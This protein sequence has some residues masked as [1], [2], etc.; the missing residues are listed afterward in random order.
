MT[1]ARSVSAGPTGVCL[2]TKRLEGAKFQWLVAPAASRLSNGLRLRI[3][4]MRLSPAQLS[5]LLEGLQWS[6]VHM[7]RVATPRAVL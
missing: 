7:R 3:G 6:R 5:A 1:N 4:V 2:V